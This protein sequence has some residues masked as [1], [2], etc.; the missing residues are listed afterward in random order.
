MQSSERMVECMVVHCLKGVLLPEEGG[1]W[2]RRSFL[3]PALRL[4]PL[5]PSLRNRR[6]GSRVEA[7][8]FKDTGKTAM[9]PEV[10]RL[11]EFE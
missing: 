1:V 10:V 7:M 11:I 8:A 3:S 2:R 9:R 5:L 6:S 4:T